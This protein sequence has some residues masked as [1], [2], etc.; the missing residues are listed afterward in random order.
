MLISTLHVFS[1]LLCAFKYSACDIQTHFYLSF[2]RAEN[3]S[4]RAEFPTQSQSSAKAR[5]AENCSIS[6]ALYAQNGELQDAVKTLT[7]TALSRGCDQ[8][9][10]YCG[11]L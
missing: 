8:S 9:D 1:D 10:S 7:P 6:Q 2:G 5:G 11:I 4:K 3:Y